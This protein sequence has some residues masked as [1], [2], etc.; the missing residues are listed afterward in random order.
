MPKDGVT[1][2]GIGEETDALGTEL[3]VDV[4]VVDDFAGEK[5]PFVGEPFAGLVGVV[6][7]AVN[8]VTE[9]EFLREMDGQAP[10]GPDVAGLL[11]LVNDGGVVGGGQLAGDR[12]LHVETLAENNRG[13]RRT[14]LSESQAPGASNLLVPV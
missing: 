12:R 2:P 10:T 9:P 7:G 1:F 14:S 11:E 4:R 8:A 5:H 3:V 6:H 13:H